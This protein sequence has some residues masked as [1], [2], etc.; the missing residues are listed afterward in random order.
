MEISEYKNIFKNEARHFLYLSRHNLVLSLLKLYLKKGSPQ[1]IT[2]LD[3]GCGTGL[4]VKKLE[5]LGKV[6]GVDVSP[7]AI[8][9]AKK[10]NVRVKKASVT[11]LSFKGDTFNVVVSIDVIY[12]QK[13]KNDEK[14]LKEFY[15]V[16][17]PNGILLLRV[18]ANQWLH[19]SHDRHVHTRQR[20]EKEELRKKLTRSGFI[21]EK[22]SFVDA[23]LLPLAFI[24]QL[25]ETIVPP[26]ATSSSAIKPLPPLLNSL[27]LL[28]LSFEVSLIKRIDLPFGIGLIAIGRKP[29]TQ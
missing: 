15:R 1:D 28:L 8:Y 7:Q 12:H 26:P 19:L 5:K 17:K 11:A 6:L 24:Q 10:R 4:L 29:V 23:L 14:A 13:V 2:I 20:Y 9:Y 21:I 27:F 3:A 18:P 16:L 22:L 25:W